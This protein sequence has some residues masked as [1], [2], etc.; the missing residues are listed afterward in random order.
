[1]TNEAPLQ[2]AILAAGQGK[3]MR[4]DLP[5]VVHPLAGR[6]LLAHVIETARTL[7]PAKFCVVVGHGADAVR[8]RFAGAGIEWAK[9]EQQLGTGHAVMQALPHLD[10]GVVL[11]L[12]GDVP[13]IAAPTLAALVAAAGKGN[14]ALLTQHLQDPKGYGRIVRAAD[15]KVARIVE[16]K[17]A[18]DAE[19][20][21]P[22]VN[23]GIVAAPRKLLAGW[24]S[25]L[26]NDNAQR[27][28]YL[29]D[30][31]AL[32]VA[33]GVAIEVRNPSAPHECLGVNS[34]SDLA[35]LERLF[36]MNQSQRLLE[37]GVTLADPAR[38]DVRGSLEC[39]RDVSIDVNCVFEGRVVLGDGVTVGA[40]CILRDVTVGGGTEVKPFSLIEEASIGANARIGPYARIR[41]GTELADDVHIGSDV[42]LVAPV[43][44]GKGATIGAG[45]TIV[46]DV[47]PGGLTLTEKKQL[48]KPGW[49][50]PTKKK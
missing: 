18:T 34:K 11:V 22:E 27:E 19:R 3:R 16:E 47:P 31:V 12:Y 5:K 46:K 48:S 17:D 33:D 6:P 14:L 50:R 24:L 43:T 26:K 4:S 1:M 32:A 23:T 13:L 29:T 15:G 30:I 38:I 25:R 37:A 28:Y 9:Q 7:S 21:I 10:D 44:V 35:A 39:G 40:N 45:A 36:Q 49:Q 8:E 42:Q 2:V 41:P 20:K